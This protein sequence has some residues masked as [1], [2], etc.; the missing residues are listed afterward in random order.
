MER[1]DGEGRGE[2]EKGPSKEGKTV[3]AQTVEAQRLGHPGRAGVG[4]APNSLPLPQEAQVT[5]PQWGHP[6]LGLPWPTVTV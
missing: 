4:R 5:A 1:R 3:H 2:E 6:G